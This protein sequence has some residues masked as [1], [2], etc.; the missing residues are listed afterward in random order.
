MR[1]RLAYVV[2]LIAMLGGCAAIAPPAA[3]PVSSSTQQAARPYWQAIDL[4]G[5]LSVQYARGGADESLHGGFTWSQSPQRTGVSL[6][7]PLGQTLAVI[8][9]QPGSA[10][11]TQSGQPPRVAADADSLAQT[12]LGW[13]LPVAGLRD[14]LQ[15]FITDP[16]GQRRAVPTDDGAAVTTADGW[17]ITYG[18]WTQDDG[19]ATPRPRRIDLARQT[20][21]A[22][23]VK[24]RIVI[25]NWQTP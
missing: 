19:S 2:A 8:D 14:W 23:L 20:V 11:L 9:V 22:G 16:Q 4:A 12:A 5:R 13:P 25:D 1:T 17:Q 24:L 10:T 21:E 18:A 3:P 7:S 6:L 15:G